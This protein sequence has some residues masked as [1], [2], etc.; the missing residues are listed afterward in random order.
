MKVETKRDL[1]IV[2]VK[3]FL[4]FTIEQRTYCCV[5]IGVNP[6]K[7]ASMNGKLKKM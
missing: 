5:Y 3:L 1:N 4:T 2:N 7:E 6:G